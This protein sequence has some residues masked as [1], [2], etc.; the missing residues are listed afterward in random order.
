MAGGHR[1]ASGGG[2]CTAECRIE[3]AARR[4]TLAP[5]AR[6]ADNKRRPARRAYGAAERIVGGSVGVAIG[7]GWVWSRREGP[8]GS[9]NLDCA[10]RHP[11]S[12]MCRLC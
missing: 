7:G 1:G 3:G 12:F 5:P 9:L 6:E 4:G 8:P 2:V 11:K 10:F